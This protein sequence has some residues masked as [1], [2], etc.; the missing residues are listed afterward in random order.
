MLSEANMTTRTNHLNAN[1]PISQ[2]NSIVVCNSQSS[3][4]NSQVSYNNTTSVNK[5]ARVIESSSCK[6]GREETIKS[7]NNVDDE[8]ELMNVERFAMILSSDVDKSIGLKSPTSAKQSS[9]ATSDCGGDGG[10]KFVGSRESKWWRSCWNGNK[11]DSEL[12]FKTIKAQQERRLADR[13]TLVSGTICNENNLENTVM[14]TTTSN[15]ITLDSSRQ[16]HVY[17]LPKPLKLRTDHRV[18]ASALASSS[19]SVATAAEATAAKRATSEEDEEDPMSDPLYASILG[20]TQLSVGPR[21]T[22]AT[23][24]SVA[25]RNPP[26]T[27]YSNATVHSPNPTDA[28]SD[29]DLASL[30]LRSLVQRCLE[31]QRATRRASLLLPQSPP[32]VDRPS[33]ATFNNSDKEL[34]V[35]TDLLATTRLQAGGQIQSQQRELFAAKRGQMQG[36]ISPNGHKEEEEEED[37]N[38]NEINSRTNNERQLS[39][40]EQQVERQPQVLSLS[41]SSDQM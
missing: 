17:A 41:S 36:L 30:Q 20:T 32:F 22:R 10:D 33:Q 18:S 16:G 28:S 35:D 29:S 7:N 8:N 11:L 9:M 37:R 13:M 6:V 21:K 27:L 38:D 40:V 25:G 34:V 4:N 26:P 1:S 31:V 14:D 23:T 24:T 15:G 2:S 3:D 19:S 12:L 39:K 5:S